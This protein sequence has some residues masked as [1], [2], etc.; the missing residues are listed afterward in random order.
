MDANQRESTPAKATADTSDLLRSL[1]LDAAATV[2]VADGDG[3]G[4]AGVGLR[5][6]LEAEHDF[7]HIA[8]L[9]LASA[10]EAG[11]RL[12]DPARGVFVNRQVVLRGSGGDNT[13][14]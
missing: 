14:N 9:R 3:E 5:R 11:D 1:N 7:Y 10:A 6:F 4:I 12:P 8:D 13:A 2:G